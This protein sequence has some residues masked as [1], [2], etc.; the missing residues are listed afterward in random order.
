MKQINGIRYW[1]SE[2]NITK[3]ILSTIDGFKTEFS[4]IADIIMMNNNE[5][6]NIVIDNKDYNLTSSVCS[7]FLQEYEVRILT[8]IY[9][10]CKNNGYIQNNVCVLCADGLMIEKHLFKPIILSEFNSL[11]KNK[12]GFDLIFSVKDMDQDYLDILDKNIFVDLYSP[13]F[14]SGLIADYFKLLYNDKFLYCN[15]QLYYYNGVYWKKDDKKYSLLSNFVDKEYY[16]Y[17]VK[18]TTNLINTLSSKINEESEDNNHKIDKL[19]ILLSNIQSLRKIKTRDSII[20]D[21]I[22]KITNNDII[23]DDNP[24]IFAFNTKIYDLKNDYFI[25]PK[26]DQYIQTTV[27]YDYDKSYDV[28]MI[29][30]LD[31][32]FNT[33][34]PSM[35]KY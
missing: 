4:K 9:I 30:E 14:S 23:F 13:V 15:D 17:L 8:E 21:I 34:F 25:E 22:N 11:I 32:L 26:Y 3:D 31:K 12:L 10:W 5:I 16:G 2:N 35:K 24:Y 19:N 18:Y 27:G 1:A 20:R 33:I 29:N 7:Y 6:K 28:N